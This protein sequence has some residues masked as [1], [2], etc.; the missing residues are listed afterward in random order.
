MCLCGACRAATLLD[1]QQRPLREDGQTA[2]R[3]SSQKVKLNSP[4]K[5][6]MAFRL[7]PLLKAKYPSYCAT[8]VC[9]YV[10]VYICMHISTYICRSSFLAELQISS[11]TSSSRS[12]LFSPPRT[13][14]PVLSR[15]AH[16]SQEISRR[17]EPRVFRSRQSS[18][19]APLQS[20][21]RGPHLP[22]AEVETRGGSS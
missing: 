12:A 20:C 15:P 8:T 5:V 9:T 21:S 16:L 4:V 10:R 14:A 17:N 13:A 2:A 22:L 3:K 11:L 18:R 19:R 7:Q 1:G 6:T